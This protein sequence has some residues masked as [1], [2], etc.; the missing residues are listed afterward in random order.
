MARYRI[1]VT[2]DEDDPSEVLDMLIEQFGDEDA[3]VEELGDEAEAATVTVKQV[4][5]GYVTHAEEICPDRD[6]TVV[7]FEGEASEM[8]ADTWI[9]AALE[10]CVAFGIDSSTIKGL[11]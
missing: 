11:T 10:L 1:E 8:E 3:S 9:A 2:I 7:D 4:I 5:A 6:E